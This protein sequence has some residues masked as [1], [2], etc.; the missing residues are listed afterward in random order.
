MGCRDPKTLHDGG[1][2]EGIA[3]ALSQMCTYPFEA[4]KAC[5]QVYGKNG[6]AIINCYRGIFQSSLTSGF[7]FGISGSTRSL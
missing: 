3:R 6:P 7:V 5:L 4:K 2:R 1:K